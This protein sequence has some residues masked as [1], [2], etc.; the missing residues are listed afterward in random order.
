MKYFRTQVYKKT[1]EDW[2]SCFKLN[3]AHD[4]PMVVVTFTKQI[5]TS[6]D[7]DGTNEDRFIIHVWGNDDFG[8]ELFDIL[9]YMTGKLIFDRILEQEFV[10]QDFLVMLGFTT[11]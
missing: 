6:K 9:H 10:T 3:D 8:M 5:E 1:N 11:V 7:L 4:T 2:Y